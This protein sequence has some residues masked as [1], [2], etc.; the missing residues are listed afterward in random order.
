MSNDNHCANISSN[1]QR[2]EKSTECPSKDWNYFYLTEDGYDLRNEYG[3]AVVKYWFN[4]SADKSEEE[5]K[6]EC[7]KKKVYSSVQKFEIDSNSYCVSNICIIFT[8]L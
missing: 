6:K 8:L 3:S 1:K 5:N 7:L 2:P 4:A